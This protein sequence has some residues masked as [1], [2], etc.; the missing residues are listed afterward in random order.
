MTS[1]APCTLLR[2]LLISGRSD[3][4]QG[5]FSFWP[6]ALLP[7]V[8]PKPRPTQGATNSKIEAAGWAAAT[9]AASEKI[10]LSG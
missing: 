7:L 4:V 10:I 8:E 2:F 9:A 6:T 5:L 3:K 1:Q